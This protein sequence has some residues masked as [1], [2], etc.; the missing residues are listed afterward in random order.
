MP[1]LQR[2]T[3]PVYNPPPPLNNTAEYKGCLIEAVEQQGFY[4]TYV[5]ILGTRRRARNME[6]AKQLIELAVGTVKEPELRPAGWIKNPPNECPH[7]RIDKEGL[8]A[9][10]VICAFFCENKNCSAY[11]LLMGNKRKSSKEVDIIELH[12]P[13][14]DEPVVPE[15]VAP[16]PQ[17]HINRRRR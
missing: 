13:F 4:V 15:P 17:T 3:R 7:T 11:I 14:G 8:W 10:S 2:P 1:R 12:V 16:A 6:H 9:E 5:T